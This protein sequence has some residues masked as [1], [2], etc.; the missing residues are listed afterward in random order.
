[1]ARTN[2]DPIRRV[3]SMLVDV[4]GARSALPLRVFS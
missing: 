1:V 2:M 4:V 3:S